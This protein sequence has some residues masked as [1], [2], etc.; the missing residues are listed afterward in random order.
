[1]S[2][3]KIAF[4]P[5]FVSSV[6][7]RSRS[8]TID[9]QVLL[10]VF[11]ILLF[12]IAISIATAMLYRHF[13]KPEYQITSSFSINPSGN[14][15]PSALTISRAKTPEE[16]Q[17]KVNAEVDFLTSKSNLLQVVQ[18]FNLSVS[19]RE[20]GLL[21]DEDLYL[22]SP[23]D[24][25]RLR[26]GAKGSGR[27][28]MTIKDKQSFIFKPEKGKKQ[29][30]TFNTTYT[31]DLGS[32]RIQRLA[33][34]SAYIGKTIRIDVMDPDLAADKLQAELDVTQSGKPQTMLN[35]SIQ[36]PVLSRGNDIINALLMSY[37]QNSAA[38]KERLA[39]GQLRFID[40]QLSKLN[41]DLSDLGSRGG[42]S[43]GLAEKEV[44]S[45]LANQFLFNVKKNDQ[46]LNRLNLKISA[47]RELEQQ[48]N[49][50]RSR[51][52][53]SLMTAV[54]EPLLNAMVR[55]LNENEYTYNRLLQT[56]LPEDPEVTGTLQQI[57]R[58]KKSIL[59]EIGVR[60]A[61]MIQEQRNLMI[62]NAGFEKNLSSLPEQEIK[63]INLARKAKGIQELYA[64]LLRTK[65]NAALNHASY[66]AF[67]KPMN[68]S[69]VVKE[70]KDLSFAVLLIGFIIPA[71][72][73]FF[74]E[75]RK[76]NQQPKSNH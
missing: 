2:T 47:L 10:K 68:N 12:C 76:T 30:Y 34:I 74:K 22:K 6:E 72:F 51:T 67:S 45:V 17:Q 53:D 65:E 18:K 66:L 7:S 14:N 69:F 41:Q 28:S 42:S 70:K 32:W 27:F 3:H 38:E 49:G 44:N 63:R 52:S 57:Q 11:K 21:H 19:Y 8:R 71:G 25:Q 31:D 26:M 1:M 60:V 54:S 23:V 36:D 50:K 13:S 75:Q 20:L 64:D 39:Q 62:A 59:E 48:F 5:D 55:T 9:K 24:F 61:P 4:R 43:A 33:N 35:L 15:Q 73:F 58:L 37:I 40:N 56:H 46:A 29:E 16:L